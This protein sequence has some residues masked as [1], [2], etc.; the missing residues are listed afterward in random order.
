MKTFNQWYTSI[1]RWL[2][3]P[4]LSTHD[5]AVVFDQPFYADITEARLRHLESLSYIFDNK[6]VMDIGC[7]IGRFTD[8]FLKHRCTLFSV[9]GRPENIQVMNKLYPAVKTAVIDLESS[10]LTVFGT[11]DVV[12]CYGLLYHL[13]DPFGF[14]KNV[15]KICNETLIIE[16]CITDS[17]DP[18]LRLVNEAQENV[19][20]SIHGIGCRPSP[21]Y[22]ITCLRMSGFHYVYEPA[23]FPAHKQFQ[24]KKQNNFSH[25]KRGNLIRGIFIASHKKI[26]APNLRECKQLFAR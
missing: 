13:A 4:I 14:I 25:V 17:E 26:S 21:S 12:F 3:S 24:Y 16:T 7:G 22:I 11:V 18:V 2:G 20:Q 19:S 15:R 1:K 10:D 5:N 9:D 8:F 23:D 6:T